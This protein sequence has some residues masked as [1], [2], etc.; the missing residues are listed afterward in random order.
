ML[1]KGS[2]DSVIISHRDIIAQ[3]LSKGASNIIIY[4][5]HPSGNPTPGLS[6]IEQTRQLS[7]ACK[8][9][10]IQLLDHIIISRDRSIASLMN[11]HVSLTQNHRKHEKADNQQGRTKR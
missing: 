11:R 5:N 6:D 4:H 8:L 1:F 3:A 7:K 10:Q 9:M 2:L